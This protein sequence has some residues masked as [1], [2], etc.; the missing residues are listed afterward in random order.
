MFINVTTSEVMTGNEHIRQLF[1]LE[2]IKDEEDLH[3]YKNLLHAMGAIFY[4]DHGMKALRAKMFQA[5]MQAMKQKLKKE[6]SR[7]VPA[8]Q[9]DTEL[10]NKEYEDYNK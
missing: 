1:K 8:I 10:A 3:N 7:A 2:Q 4:T 6:P 5:W 9:I